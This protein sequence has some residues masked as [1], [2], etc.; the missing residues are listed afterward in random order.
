MP[1]IGDLLV[2]G[3]SRFRD[4]DRRD[5]Y[6]MGR[7]RLNALEHCQHA[8]PFLRLNAA[9]PRESWLPNNTS[10]N[11]TA[12]TK[13]LIGH[14]RR[15]AVK[16]RSTGLSLYPEWCQRTCGA[17]CLG[18]RILGPPGAPKIGVRL[19]PPPSNICT[20]MDLAVFRLFVAH[21]VRLY[22]VVCPYV[23]WSRPRHRLTPR[24]WS[25]LTN[26]DQTRGES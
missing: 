20:P 12:W 4:L 17:A 15:R 19:C 14:S 9:R 8:S 13:R 1:Q 10:L 2:G 18:E 21:S 25:L 23:T 3:I 24:V 26:H 7:Q 22:L 16:R 5:A 6:V 11:A